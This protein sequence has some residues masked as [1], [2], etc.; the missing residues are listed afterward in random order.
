MSTTA[1]TTLTFDQVLEFPSPLATFTSREVMP[2]A[3]STTASSASSSEE[4]KE[5]MTNRRKRKSAMSQ[6]EKAKRRR[7]QNR[8]AAQ[9]SRQRKKNYINTLEQKVA[10]LEKENNHLQKI[11]R[12]KEQQ[13]SQLTFRLD[14]Q[15]ST[16]PKQR[17]I[18]EELSETS[19]VS[20][21]SNH[22]SE[23]NQHND[24]AAIVSPQLEVLTQMLM[25]LAVWAQMLPALM[26]YVYQISQYNSLSSLLPK[27]KSM[28]Q[29]CNTPQAPLTLSPQI[30]E[31]RSLLQSPRF[32]RA[33]FHYLSQS[34]NG[35]DCN[36]QSSRGSTSLSPD[37]LTSREWISS[38]PPMARPASMPTTRTS[39]L[40][41]TQLCITQRGNRTRNNNQGTSPISFLRIRPH[42][43]RYHVRS[44]RFKLR[45]K[46][47]H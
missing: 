32:R 21:D 33:V 39:P 10:S 4:P 17:T 44:I 1:T 43:R 7:Q 12:E 27:S 25:F 9:K 47:Q 28:E 46:M 8:Q 6:E 37:N 19:S 20:F 3:L 14:A 40:S 24:S 18:L 2:F 5:K 45:P 23:V 38:L 16:Y 41:S 22:Q 13:I 31:M 15:S 36:Q 30:Q 11:I 34:Q 26:V 35:T 42:S 29:H